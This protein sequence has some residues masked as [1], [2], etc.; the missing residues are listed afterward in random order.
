M[1]CVIP[2]I[3]ALAVLAIVPLISVTRTAAR[4]GGR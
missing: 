2:M 4:G 3:E 1:F